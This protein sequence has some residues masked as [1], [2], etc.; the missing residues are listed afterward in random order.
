MSAARPGIAL[1]PPSSGGAEAP[2]SLP[3]VTGSEIGRRLNS[4]L[5]VASVLLAAILKRL[6]ISIP[7]LFVVSILIFVVL[8]LLPADPVGM[9]IPPNATPE[10]V[11]VLR[12]RL[13]LDGS[14]IHQYQVWLLRLLQGD[15]GNS[16][17]AGLPVSQLIVKALPTTIQL[18]IL[19]MSFGVAI[20]FAGGLL[21]FF[22]RGTPIEGAAEVGNALT[23]S[24][25]DFLWAILLILI[26]GIGFKLLPFVG[27]IDPSYTVPAR[28]GF[29]LIDTLLAGDIRA[30]FN[31]LGHFVLPVLA[32]GMSKGALVMRVLR[33]SL[34]EAYTEEYIV[35]A[36]LRGVSEIRIMLRHALKNAVLPTV[37]LIGV[38]SATVFGSTLL[39]ETIYSLPGIGSLMVGAVRAHDLPVIQSLALIYALVVMVTNA[40]VDAVHTLLDPRLTKK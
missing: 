34:L 30:F 17:Q 21:S 5:H 12:H 26:F 38:L 1:V 25:P 10:D 39:I 24:I 2:K 3:P 18:V 20:G 27:L 31:V 32:L 7:M 13:G 11:A 23:I 37:S 6:V 29:L 36:R 40:V 16:I 28:T 9:L 35:A 19:G 22:L 33:S 15:F 4:I 8:R 14:I